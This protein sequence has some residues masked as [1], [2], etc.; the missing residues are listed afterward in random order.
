MAILTKKRNG[1]KTKSNKKSKSRIRK[2]KSINKK[3]MRDGVKKKLY[4]GAIPKLYTVPNDMRS[5]EIVDYSFTNPN[6]SGNSLISGYQKTNKLTSGYAKIPSD[7]DYIEIDE[8]RPNSINYERYNKLMYPPKNL[9]SS[10]SIPYINPKEYSHLNP[11]EGNKLVM[12][13]TSYGIRRKIGALVPVT[14]YSNNK[15]KTRTPVKIPNIFETKYTKI[16]T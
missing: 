4:G 16:S 14:N 3:K 12:P 13:R 6:T 2:N 8:I 9:S 1:Y 5:H 11:N 10:N 7:S 15:T